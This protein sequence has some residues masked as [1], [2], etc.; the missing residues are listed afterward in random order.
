MAG[1][2]V[3]RRFKS[4][5]LISVDVATE[6]VTLAENRA[7][8]LEPLR[9]APDTTKK[10]DHETNVVRGTYGHGDLCHSDLWAGRSKGHAATLDE[11]R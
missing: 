4:G 3:V 11:L 6:S 10:R 5:S 8:Q 9:H 7:P 2:A 1:D